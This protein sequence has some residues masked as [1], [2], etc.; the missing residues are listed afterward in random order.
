MA[1]LSERLGFDLTDTLTRNVEFL[2]DFLKG[3][4]TAVIQTE[5]QAKDLLFSLCQRAQH[6]NELL[7]QKRKGCCI[8]RDRN[9]VILNKISEMAVLL[10]ADRCLEGDRLL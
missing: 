9:I 2:A 8:C 10:L 5:P 7:F 4:G 1:K 3:A 6:F